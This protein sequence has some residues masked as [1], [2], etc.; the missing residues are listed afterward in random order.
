MEYKKQ[1]FIPRSYLAPWTDPLTPP[2]YEPYVWIIDKSTL[3]TS[4]RAPKNI[5]FEIDLYTTET[6]EGERDNSFEKILSKIEG[7][8]VQVR[9]REITNHLPLDFS[10]RLSLITFVAAMHS[11]TPSSGEKWKPVWQNMLD[12]MK[13]FQA[14]SSKNE[15]KMIS[16]Y[17]HSP[18]IDFGDSNIIEDIQNLVDDPIPSMLVSSI[19]TEVKLLMD[20][21]I[22]I[23][24]T[25]TSPGF[26]TSDNPVV[27]VNPQPYQRPAL[28][29]PSIEISMPISPAYNLLLNKQGNS[30]YVDLGNYG[31]HIDLE[32]VEI[33]NQR[34]N[35]FAQD[36]LILNKNTLIWDWLL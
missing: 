35:D 2:N 36:Y 32:T 15:S 10:S 19:L 20:L 12:K 21:D 30:G 9:D 6:E 17:F 8:F 22:V 11:R 27:W 29:Y 25:R 23:L 28:I 33:A 3:K 31:P 13:S 5:L 14:Y 4:N 18:L 24:H 1:H 34:V 26:I 7:E 16:D